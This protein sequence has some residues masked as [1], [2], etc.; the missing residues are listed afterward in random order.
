MK[1]EKKYIVAGAIM[2]G[3]IS[4]GLLYLQ[5]QKMKDFCLSMKQIQVI[6][7]AWTAA[8]INM[9]INFRNKSKF[10]MTLFSQEYIIYLNDKFVAK[11]SNTVP[12]IVLANAI[13][14]LSAKLEFNPRDVLQTLKMNI[15][16]LL[17]NPD[18][19]NIKI[20]INVEAGIGIL[21]FSVPYNYIT[22]LKELTTS[23][24]PNDQS[25]TKC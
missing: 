14:V 24:T 13:S 1:I 5:F 17:L 15:T 2:L 6:N 20:A 8:N 25:S 9:Y 10:K 19:I 18:K 4:L 21:K 22:T 7:F 16:D 12:Q 11:V 23:S 3:S